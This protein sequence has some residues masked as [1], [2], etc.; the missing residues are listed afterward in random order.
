MFNEEDSVRHRNPIQ[1]FKTRPKRTLQ[2][3]SSQNM[4]NQGHLKTEFP[5]KSLSARY[6]KPH[7]PR[8]GFQ[9]ASFKP[10]KE[11]EIFKTNKNELSQRIM[12]EEESQIKRDG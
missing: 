5:D 11:P 7:E 1:K 8:A 12:T 3:N 4:R 10:Q 2:Q 6:V 9:K